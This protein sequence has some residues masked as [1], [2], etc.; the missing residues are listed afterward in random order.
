MVQITGPGVTSGSVKKGEKMKKKIATIMAVTT[1]ICSAL[2]VAGCAKDT[3]TALPDTAASVEGS[4]QD[5]RAFL[6]DE[7]GYTEAD[8]AGLD[9]EALVEDYQLRTENYT[10]QEVDEILSEYRHV[11]ELTE[12]DEIYRIL[13]DPDQ[14]CSDSPDLPEGADI[15]KIAVYISSGT[16]QKRYLFDLDND[17]FYADDAV[18]Q[19]LTAGQK[20]QMLSAIT[21][22]QIDKWPHYT[23]N[24][25]SEQP[26]TGSFGWKFAF[27]LRNGTVCS[28][29]GYTKDMT[30][31]PEGFDIFYSAIPDVQEHQ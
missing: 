10:R 8:L 22:A 4:G 2:A 3:Q 25:R 15:A 16:S 31:L 17:S 6:M 29:G 9:T 13:R 12:E 26:S 27:Q 21:E 24:T 19:D 5:A 1:V 11:Y 18:R 30:G 28:Y 23:D 7:F 14:D 20:E